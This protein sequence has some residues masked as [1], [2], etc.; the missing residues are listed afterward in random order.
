MSYKKGFDS[1]S[2]SKAVSKILKQ[3]FLYKRQG[4]DKAFLA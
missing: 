3:S 2:F 4:W 1:F